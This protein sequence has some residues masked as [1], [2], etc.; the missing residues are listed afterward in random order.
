MSILSVSEECRDVWND[1]FRWKE[2]GLCEA[3]SSD[4]E[5]VR[6]NCED[7]CDQCSGNEG[8][9]GGTHVNYS[10]VK[11]NFNNEFQ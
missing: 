10:K 8:K 5:R 11:I 2:M 6:L 1:C 7:T 4:G 9:D 3:L